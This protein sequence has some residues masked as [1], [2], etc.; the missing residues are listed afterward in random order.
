MRL[1]QP[2]AVDTADPVDNDVIIGVVGVSSVGVRSAKWRERDAA[3]VVGQEAMKGTYSFSKYGNVL[4]RKRS[5]AI[6]W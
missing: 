5:I 1:C 2:F 4:M 3:A 6:S